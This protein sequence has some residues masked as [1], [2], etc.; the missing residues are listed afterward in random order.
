MYFTHCFCC[1]AVIKHLVLHWQPDLPSCYFMDSPSFT[2]FQFCVLKKNTRWCKGC[3]VEVK[4]PL[5]CSV[6]RHSWFLSE[7][8]QHIHGHCGL[9]DEA[10]PKMHGKLSICACQSHDKVV[11]PCSDEPIFCI[12]TINVWGHQLAS[13]VFL[14]IKFLEA[15]WWL[16]IQT[17]YPCYVACIC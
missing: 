16:T 5:N 10:T 4:W 7:G 2:M 6:C 11:F 14:L 17:M 1:T 8:S 13:N 3:F 12:Y 9:W 15:C